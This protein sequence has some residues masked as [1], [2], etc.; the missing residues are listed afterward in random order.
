MDTLRFADAYAAYSDA[1]AIT[2]DTALLYNMGRALQALNRFPEALTKLEAFQA[3]ASPELLAK[4]P[5]LGQLILDLR[6]QV[7][8]LKVA[9][10]V[11][12]ARVLVRSTVMG[13][14]PLA[15]PLRL[16]AG[17]AEIEVE[18][19]GYFPFHT[20]LDLPGGGEAVVDAKLFSKS[21]TGLLVVRASAP[22]SMVYV[23]ERRVGLAPVE[24]NVPGGNHRIRV[25]NID[26][27]DYE[28]TAVV[29]TGTRK[30]LD[31]KLLPPLIVTRWWF[32]GS[33]ALVGAA[34]GAIGYA[35]TTERAPDRGDI[36]PGQIKTSSFRLG[37]M[38]P[39]VKF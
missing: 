10:N 5:K 39:V 18:A 8:T 32:W 12:D 14:L 4:V 20:V 37:V 21:T 9:A 13:K 34:A 30:D 17:Q 31:V 25:T 6:K 38:M 22:G 16:T 19:D 23:D 26:F 24:L 28:T 29:A 27:R 35:A 7:S 15:E 1:Y 36:L 2:R 33:V 3:V 11:P